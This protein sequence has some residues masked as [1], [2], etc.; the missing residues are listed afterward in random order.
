MN[1]GFTTTQMLGGIFLIVLGLA[2]VLFA[3]RIVECCVRTDSKRINVG[4]DLIIGYNE[5]TLK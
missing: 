3:A 4:S 2:S 5:M 1:A